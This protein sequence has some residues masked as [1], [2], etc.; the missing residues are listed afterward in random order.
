MSEGAKDSVPD[1]NMDFEKLLEMTV[2]EDTESSSQ[3]RTT[4]IA[5]GLGS[6]LKKSSDGT[7]LGPK[8]VIRAP[9]P[10]VGDRSNARIL[11]K[12]C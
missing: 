1:I 11:L 9:K 12:R 5:L 6:A 10:K 3:L 4:P 7:I 8:V 2:Q